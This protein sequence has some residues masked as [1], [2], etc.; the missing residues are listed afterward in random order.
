[1]EAILKTVLY[2]WLERNLPGTLEREKKLDL[3]EEDL[4]KS[5]LTCQ[6]G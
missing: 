5:F 1:M 3:K 6:V 4:V 2:E